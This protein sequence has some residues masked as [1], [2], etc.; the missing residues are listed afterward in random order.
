MDKLKWHGVLPPNLTEVEEQVKADI[1]WNFDL[2]ESPS[3]LIFHHV[4]LTNDYKG[5]SVII[6]GEEGDDEC[7]HCEYYTVTKLIS[8][9]DE[10][11]IDNTSKISYK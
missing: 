2:L 9:D 3:K 1:K 5:P 11:D 4:F 10:E 6:W 8:L 7:F